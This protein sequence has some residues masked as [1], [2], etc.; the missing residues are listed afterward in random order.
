M[1]TEVQCANE[2]CALGE[3]D[4]VTG[5]RGR[6]WFKPQRA[7][8]RFCCSQCRM[9]EVMVRRK[10]ALD[11]LREVEDPTGGVAE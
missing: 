3:P 11:M 5:A 8:G 6:K 9:A 1:M 7:W 2:K 10:V 4:P